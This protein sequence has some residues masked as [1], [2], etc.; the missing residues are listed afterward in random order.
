[1]EFIEDRIAP[2]M[3]AKIDYEEWEKGGC[4]KA[5]ALLDKNSRG[6]ENEQIK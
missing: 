6:I 3:D 4:E 1:M 5:K 2:T